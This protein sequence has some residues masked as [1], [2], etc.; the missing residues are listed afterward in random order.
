MQGESV[1]IAFHPFAP[2]GFLI[3]GEVNSIWH[4]TS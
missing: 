2:V 4:V 3:S 1:N